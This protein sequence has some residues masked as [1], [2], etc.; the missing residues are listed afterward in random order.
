MTTAT[1]DHQSRREAYAK[2]AQREQDERLLKRAGALSRM[3]EG[4]AARVE[5]RRRA[6]W[7]EVSKLGATGRSGGRDFTVT[8]RG[9]G[10]ATA[11]FDDGETRVV[12]APTPCM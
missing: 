1:L 11:T 8:E 6:S 5:H 3:L 7:P 2:T 4:W 10:Y 12:Y 9:A